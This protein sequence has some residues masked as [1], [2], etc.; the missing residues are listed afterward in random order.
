MLL[1]SHDRAQ[2]REVCD[3]FWLV[4]GGKVESFDGDLDDYQRWLLGNAR[5][6]QRQARESSRAAKAAVAAPPAPPPPP[7]PDFR[8]LKPL[9][10][11][12]AKVDAALARLNDERA[13][14]EAALGDGRASP[15]QIAEH[16]KRLKRI[17]EETAPL[18]ERWLELQGEIDALS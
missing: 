1:V 11:E 17:A 10:Q 14:L 2:L 15:A 6:A 3:E 9:K 12:L 7:A 5:E 16:G 4:A 8:R 18:E 13:A